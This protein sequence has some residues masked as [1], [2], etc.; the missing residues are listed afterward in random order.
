MDEKPYQLLGQTRDPIPRGSRTGIGHWV[1][2]TP[3]VA[4][5]TPLKPQLETFEKPTDVVP[6]VTPATN[7]KV[8]QLACLDSRHHAHADAPFPVTSCRR[9]TGLDGPDRHRVNRDRCFD[10]LT[11]PEIVCSPRMGSAYAHALHALQRCSMPTPCNYSMVCSPTARVRAVKYYPEGPQV[12]SR[13]PWS[14]TAWPR[15]TDR[16]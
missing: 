13:A 15:S 9:M 2:L 6:T 7:T 4:Y 16:G 10:L 5:T 1:R 3:T 11:S 12:C 8:G 14:C